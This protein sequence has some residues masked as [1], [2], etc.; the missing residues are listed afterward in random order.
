MPKKIVKNPYDLL[1][2]YQR[3]WVE[4]QSRF[5]LAIWSRQIGKSFAEACEIVTDSY[6]H[7]TNLWLVGSAG[8]RQALEFMGKVKQWTEALGFTIADYKEERDGPQALIKSAEVILPNKSRIVAVP[9]NPDTMRG[10]SANVA[11]DEIDFIEDQEGVWRAVYPSISNP[12]RGEKKMRAMTTPN[13]FGRLAHK[14]TQNAEWSKHIVTIHDAIAQGLQLDAE[15]LR[16]GLNDPEAWAQEY[17]C[18]FLDASAVLLPYDLIASC[19]SLECLGTV[20]PDFYEARRRPLVGGLDFGRKRDLTVLW[21]LEPIGDVHWT[22]HVLV[23]EKMSTPDQVN[24]LRPILRRLTRLC[25]DYTGAGV[26]L[27]DYL[28]KEFGEYK[29]DAHLFGKIELCQFT[30]GFKTDVFPKLRM[31][32]EAKTLRIPVDRTIREDLH[33]VHRVTTQNGTVTYKAPHTEDGHSDRATALALAVRA[34]STTG[35]AISTVE[36][37]RLGTTSGRMGSFKP[38]TLR[39]NA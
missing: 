16:A 18:Q 27:G 29:P 8:E 23:L 12:L 6:Q 39:R 20:D 32:F 28:A 17:E 3:R 37:I 10:Y 25:L 36:G 15:K 34:A 22:R 35:G 4:D 7:A 33:A 31:K 9:A 5:K 30:A 26:G 21:V 24:I 13:G 11:L 14:L 1:L 2:P 38:R 19:E